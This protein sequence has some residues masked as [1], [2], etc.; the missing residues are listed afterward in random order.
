MLSAA[1]F[2]GILNLIK[3]FQH[4]LVS[5]V[6]KFWKLYKQGGITYK[7]CIGKNSKLFALS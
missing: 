6:N 5:N 4:T 2:T 1:D 3:W 7:K